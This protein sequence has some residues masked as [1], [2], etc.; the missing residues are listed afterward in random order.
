VSGG[1]TDTQ[2]R[3]T[4]VPVSGT[5]TATGPLTDTQLRATPVPVSGGLTDTQLRATPVPVSGTVT[6]T[7]PLTDT[8]LRATPV[9]VSGGLTDTQLRATP[10]PVSGTVT[11]TGPLTDT[12]LRATPVPV[13]GTVSANS[14]SIVSASNSSTAPLG[15]GATFTGSGTSLLNY[16]GV[17]VSVFSNVS[18][19][20]DGVQIQFSTDNTN[21]NDAVVTSYVIGGVAPNNGQVWTAGSRGQFVRIV[22]TN[23]GTIQASFRLQTILLG[24]PFTADTVD[25]SEALGLNNH[26]LITKSLITGKTTAGGGS[27]VDVKVSPSGSLASDVSNSANVGIVSSTIATASN[28]GTCTSVSVSATVLASNP[29]RKVATI[30]NSLSSTDNVHVKL[31]SVA[32]T[33]NPPIAPGQSLTISSNTVYTGVVDAVASTGTQTVCVYEW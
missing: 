13:S 6:A 25:I 24:S 31:G 17:L 23:G 16:A 1:L 7:G 28:T 21:W 29:S 15:A 27:F 30:Y 2:L 4:P 33:S 10:V 19:A 20:T 32:T 22:Y 18:S 14:A 3:A 8:Q 5:V 9:P 26:A 12:Q 11:A